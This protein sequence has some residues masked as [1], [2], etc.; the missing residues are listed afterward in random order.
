MSGINKISSELRLKIVGY[1]L[2]LG[3]VYFPVF[4]HL[5]NLSIREWDEARLAINAYEM[6]RDGDIIVTHFNSLPDM[7]NTKPSLMVWFQSVGM[8][9]FGPGELA[10]RLPSA[11]AAL[12]LIFGFLYFS[13]KYIKSFWFGAFAVLVLITA[14]GYIQKHAT[15]TGDYDSLLTL[16]T[17]MH[18]L[19]FLYYIETRKNI[20]LYL[21]FMMVTLAVLTKSIQGLLFLPGL[22]I[23]TLI[24]K[25]IVH[26][27]KN[28]HFYFGMLIFIVFVGGYYLLRESVNPG[29]LEAVYNNELGGRYLETIEEHQEPFWFYF[30]NIRLVFFKEWFWFLPF[31]LVAGYFS[32][33]REIRQV[34]LF[35]LIMIVSY[36]LIISSSKTKLYWY[37]VPLYPFM[38]LIIAALIHFIFI[39]IKNKLRIRKA[40]WIKP[41]L[42]TILLVGLF[43]KP[44]KKIIDTFYNAQTT[45]YEQKTFEHEYL[46][47]DA[48]EGKYNLQNHVIIH[49]GYNVHLLFYVYQLN[50]QGINIQFIQKEGIQKGMK[51][52]AHQD[53]IKNYIEN[54]FTFEITYEGW[55]VKI[56]NING[57][58]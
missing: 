55:K 54:N 51:V 8:H 42:M 15:R 32:R 46:L 6:Y 41:L 29:Y 48:V 1:V 39:F 21:S 5:E 13:E 4:G 20:A 10:V 23:F 53:E 11:L 57:S 45:S 37:D 19:A 34:T 26:L 22:F 18:C 49:Q 14:G 52:I 50:D 17:T 31:G 43:Y 36:F 7:W 35:S 3:L 12:F 38:A 24:R 56:Y 30:N 47:R 33:K 28:R 27:I 9:I 25:D 16:F 58:K 44:Y 40:T 2:L